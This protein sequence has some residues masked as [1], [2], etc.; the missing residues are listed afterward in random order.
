ME[1]KAI[2][3]L[4]WT[5]LSFGLNKGV[6]VLTTLILA[7]LLVPADFGIMALALVATNFLYWFG[8]ISFG[9]VLVVRQEL[10]RHQQG[11]ILTLAVGFAGAAAGVT[12]VVSPLAAKLFHEPRLTGVLAG[13]SVAVL[14][15]GVT[16]FYESLLQREMEFRRR[17]AGLAS[18]TAVYATVAITLA[19]LGAG[20]WSLVAAQVG[21]FGVFVIVM[22]ALA[23]YRVRPAWDPALARS[24]FATGRGFFAQGITVF[25]RQNVDT[26]A[27]GRFFSAGALG[28][29]SMAFRLGD[30]TYWTIADPIARVT[31]PS[32][33]RSRHRGEDI[34]PTFLQVIRMVA[35]VA[36]PAGMLL[37]ATADPLTRVVF[38]ERWLRMIGPLAIV[39]VWAAVRPVEATVS[40]LLNSVQR[41]GA[42]GWVSVVILI[43]LVPG[44]IV[45]AAFGGL[46]AVAAIPLFDTILSLGALAMLARRYLELSP[47][48]L[49]RALMPVAVSAP[50]MWLTTYATHRVIGDERALLGL[51][52]SVLVGLTVYLVS[53][54]LLDRSLLVGAWT[55][56]RRALGRGVPAPA[57]L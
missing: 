48:A 33:A 38:G 56:I 9:S 10:D 24:V 15:S 39:G 29:Y 7:R 42:T 18:Q 17:F 49:G 53:V 26:L 52:A 23:P 30:L 46:T 8:G 16:S 41:A 14:I 1:D 40:W 12:L 55:Q 34:R 6:S 3:G 27:V 54:T 44:V 20:V 25:I 13:M 45:A 32:F 4:P 22:V 35:L 21:S 47:T 51:F 36:C 11:T 31:F 57:P 43:P 5:L 50:L 37:S 2:R 28:F 19:S